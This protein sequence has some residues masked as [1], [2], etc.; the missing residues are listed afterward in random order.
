MLRFFPIA[1]I[2]QKCLIH[3]A[4]CLPD[5][6]CR[7]AA[8][9]SPCSPAPPPTTSSSSPPTRRFP[10][11]DSCA[12]ATRHHEPCTP[13]PPPTHLRRSGVCL[14][15][16]PR[17]SRPRHVTCTGR[18]APLC[19]ARSMTSWA[20]RLSRQGTGGAAV[21]LSVLGQVRW[22]LLAW[23]TRSRRTANHCVS[24]NTPATNT[25]LLLPYPAA[26]VTAP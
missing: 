22:R 26:T 23:P 20:P 12:T 9:S 16:N 1:T 19:P 3:P 6:P 25:R 4:Q 7:A 10:H 21:E 14:R 8:A 15:P 11:L 13:L 2:S 24:T 17:L 5:H 18:T